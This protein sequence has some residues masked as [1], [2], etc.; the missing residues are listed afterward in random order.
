MNTHYKFTK[1][2]SF[3]KGKFLLM[4]LFLAGVA[5]AQLSGSYTIDAAST[6]SG[7]NF[8]NWYDFAST[9]TSKGVSAA[10]TVTVKSDVTTS[11]QT[12]FGAI[13]G[14]SSTN[15]I[16]I[17]GGS[18]VLSYGGSYE[19][20]SFT[21]A[22]YVTIKN[23]TLRNTTAASYA[24]IVRL[25]TSSDY[26]KIDNCIMEFTTLVSATSATYY[27]AFSNYN[28][29]PSSATSVSNGKGNTI[30]NCTMRTT[31]TNAAGPY[32]GITCMGNTSYYSSVGDD[33]NIT[34]NK[35][36]NYYYIAILNYYG[37]GNQFT[38]NDISRTN[39]TSSSGVSSTM[40]GIYSYYTYGTNRSTVYRSNNMHDLPY[41]NA[42]SSS[43][44]NYIQVWYG[45]YA[46]YNY[47]TTTYPFVVDQN[48][49]K[50]VM[51]YYYAYMYYMY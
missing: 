42:A 18:K 38:S 36:Q 4:L 29:S 24:G 43:T 6:T 7:T 1:S 47:G 5:N 26:N 27:V 19:A 15:T 31:G 32:Y 25:T 48:T 35:I 39:A 23:A 28:T 40:M 20:I 45:M 41:L 51:V 16:T 37:N 17:D 50:N 14:A 2:A 46:Y 21:G 33:N 34:S 30:S 10:V 11:T 44:T 13:S 12:V 49:Q 9:V 22:D 3:L 8:N